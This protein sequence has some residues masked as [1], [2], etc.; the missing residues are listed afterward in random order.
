MQ[1]VG[2][3]HSFNPLNKYAYYQI[4]TDN[5]CKPEYCLDEMKRVSNGDP[6]N[7]S[8]FYIWDG[9]LIDSLHAVYKNLQSALIDKI[10]ENNKYNIQLD[11][12]YD[13]GKEIINITVSVVGMTIPAESATIR[14]TKS[15]VQKLIAKGLIFQFKVLIDALRPKFSY[16][17]SLYCAYISQLVGL[18]D[19]EQNNN[20]VIA[21]PFYYALIDVSN[22]MPAKSYSYID[23]L[24]SIT[25]LI[26]N[27][28]NIYSSD[29]I[30]Y[31]VSNSF[32]TRGKFYSFESEN[33]DLNNIE[34]INV[35]NIDDIMPTSQ[36]IDLIS[37]PY[38][39]DPLNYGE[40]AWRHFTA[41]SEGDYSFFVNNASA[42]I[43]VFN[44]VV[45]GYSNEN[46]ISYLRENIYK[47]DL[48]ALGISYEKHML[49]GETSYFRVSGLNYAALPSIPYIVYDYFLSD[50]LHTH[51]YDTNYEWKNLYQ[52]EAQCR[53]SDIALKGHVVSS[54]GGGTLAAG[55]IGS[56]KY[57]ILCG[58]E[59]VGL[60]GPF[61]INSTNLISK[62]IIYFSNGSY[63]FNGI[64][65]LSDID[66]QLFYKNKLIIPEY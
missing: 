52:H 18:T 51:R 64:V 36:K 10:N 42:T 3:A 37:V 62:N 54:S 53:C 4:N 9:D 65:Y 11:T 34:L 48:N 50:V 7:L 58:G 38:S 66:L 19:R 14:I 41:P 35:S 22:I 33:N 61:I 28:S 40:Y 44:S 1:P 43:S 46:R 23:F 55:L 60:V 63:I 27:N 5:I 29:C 12:A 6:I 16:S 13:I 2:L 39:I 21:I 15:L 26:D 56:K 59:A 30:S 31:N 45:K 8:T 17:G 20:D 47:E 57:C 25:K 24:P 32:Y 49:E